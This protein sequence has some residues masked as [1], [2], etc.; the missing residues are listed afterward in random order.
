MADN[1]SVVDRYA[2]AVQDRDWRAVHAMLHPDYV[3]EFPQSGEIIRGRDNF[4]AIY[5][6]MEEQLPAAEH[7]ETTGEPPQ[8]VQVAASMGFG[9]PIIV[10][11]GGGGDSYTVSGEVE[12]PNGDMYHVVSILHLQDGL[13]D[14]ETV[15]FAEPFEPPPWR[16]QWVEITAT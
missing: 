2:R 15:Y 4:E 5:S 7:L 9:M 3:G 16:R 14:R 10:V 13:I 12:Y 1:R 11:T 6:Q 8:H